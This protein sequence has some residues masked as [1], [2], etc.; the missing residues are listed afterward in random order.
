MDTLT[1]PLTTLLLIPL[2]PPPLSAICLRLPLVAIFLLV[3]LHQRTGTPPAIA[4]AL[5][6]A[7]HLPA[8]R[9]QCKHT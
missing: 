4:D 7:A 9:T 3:E 1:L 5:I 6:R 8:L 2:S